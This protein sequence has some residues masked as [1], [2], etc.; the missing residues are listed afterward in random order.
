MT[1]NKI[2]LEDLPCT[3]QKRSGAF[4]C[5]A[6]FE[7]RSKYVADYIKNLNIQK[8]FIFANQ[9]FHESI[10]HNADE[11]G[12]LFSVKG[13]TI[14]TALHAPL[15]TADAI[16]R[17]IKE[18]VEIGIDDLIVDI[19][20]FTH[21]MLLIILRLLFL[22]KNHFQK[23]TCVYTGAKEYSIGEPDE[24]KWLSKGC[25]EVRSVIGYPGKIV[26]GRPTSLLVLVGFEHERA[27]RMISEM[28]PEY[29]LLGKGMSGQTTHKSH[30]APMKI[31]HSLVQDMVSSR[32]KIT[33]FE[34]SCKDPYMTS[35]VIYDLCENDKD[36]NHIVVPLN[37]KIS[38]I[39]VAL[40]AL[41]NNSIQVCYAE[42]EHYNF[43]GY[44]SPD[45]YVRVFDLI[46]DNI[47]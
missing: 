6:S 5:C 10:L 16:T 26:P 42:P 11:I 3:L 15:E 28:D 35:K 37:T 29:L 14:K 22:H 9:D 27:M 12:G 32:G 25:K 19:T 41:K 21:E 47:E 2:A 18:I 33:E 20:T 36:Q 43:E 44:S 23:I 30:K 34:F 46:W 40:A 4:I 13:K 38:T 39:G 8:A 24:R 7:S 1:G 31:F 17:T 45:K